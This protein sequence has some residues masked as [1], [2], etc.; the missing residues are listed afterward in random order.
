MTL[1]DFSA[2]LEQTVQNR[3]SRAHPF[4]ERWVRGGLTRN[5]LGQW[6]IQQWHFIGNFSQYMA[7][8]YARCPER[9]VRDYLLE[10]MWEEE[11][12][13]TR[14]SEY[15]VRF[16]AACGVDRERFLATAPLSTTEA[17]VDWC[18]ARACYDHWLVAAAALNIGLESQVV[19]IMERVTPP[20]IEKYGFTSA[21]I[22]YFEIHW[23]T[24]RVH[25]ARA[26]EL[27]SKHAT[28][29]ELRAECIARVAR[30]TDMRWL[31]TDGIYRAFVI[32]ADAE[33]SNGASF[34][35]PAAQSQ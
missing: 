4:T 25:S 33:R 6:A 34:I 23:K 15:L 31:F 12:A 11:L 19:G 20:L 2:E 5:Q 17:L 32:D 1:P 18:R 35:R 16:A 27:I 21:D 24:D 3:H 8:V 29:S 7:G 26:Y 30:A 13:A 14:H 9:E 28:S 10:N 22:G